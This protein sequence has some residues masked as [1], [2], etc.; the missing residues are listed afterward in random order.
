MSRLL[1]PFYSRD[2]LTVA[3]DLL[4]QR[5]VRQIDTQQGPIR[6]SGRIVELEA[7]VGQGDEA[8]H[9][10]R[11]RTPRT[12]VMF[13][14]P[15]HAYVYFIYGMH[16]CFNV[17]TEPEGAAAAVLIRAL[18]PV[19][20]ID[21]MRI[22]RRGRGGVQLTNGPAKL[23]YALGI[24]KTLNKVDLVTSDSLWLERDKRVDM[25]HIAAG[26]R[27][28]VTGDEQ[29]IT[30]EWRFWIKENPYVSK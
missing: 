1:R 29:A 9:A 13:G 27:I 24:D 25:S 21:E 17:V 26:P 4:G 23:C 19:E 12:E 7:Y 11:G 30:V 20:G 10:S 18:E 6:V 28:G 8:C 14:P 16:Y 3:R 15:G 2:T 22:R 5:L